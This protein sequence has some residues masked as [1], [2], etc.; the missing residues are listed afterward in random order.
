MSNAYENINYLIE[1]AGGTT[2][3]FGTYRHQGEKGG[4]AEFNL[5]KNVLNKRPSMR[6]GIP[7]DKEAM[8]E[9]FLNQ[10]TKEG[11]PQDF[12]F[13]FSKGF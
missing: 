5:L 8:L 1:G 13:K 2:D 12:G 3:P 6:F 7:I 11:L 9:F 4:Y 10:Y